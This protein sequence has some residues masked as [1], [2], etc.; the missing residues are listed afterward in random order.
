[1]NPPSPQEATSAGVSSLPDGQSPPL[2]PPAKR[3]R[4]ADV[5][6]VQRAYPWMLFASTGVA[7]LFCFMYIN[8][9]VLMQGAGPL[10]PSE[11][12]AA[13]TV[14]SPIPAISPGITEVDDP[15]DALE[16]AAEPLAGSADEPPLLP[17]PDRLPGE[18]ASGLD[19]LPQ[20]APGRTLPAPAAASPYEETNLRVQHVLSAES[21]DGAQSRIILD[22]PVLYESRQLRWTTRESH[23]ARELLIRLVEHQEKTRSLRDEGEILLQAW[24]SMVERSIPASELRADS[25][26]LP[27]NQSDAAASPRPA[28]FDTGEAIRIQS[29]QD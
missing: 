16:P 5:C 22:V 11:P 3:G 13:A 24:N 14:E 27:T 6:P 20:P 29:Q 7:A 9:P 18:L 28:G 15:F 25:P 2:Q 23:E 26:T 12:L 1:M 19:I 4:D 21:A 17:P 8:K 10:M